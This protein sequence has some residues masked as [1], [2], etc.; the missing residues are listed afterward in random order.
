MH[1]WVTITE[2]PTVQR[3][4]SIGKRKRREPSPVPKIVMFY[5]YR[6][7]PCR[8]LKVTI[9]S[10]AQAQ[11]TARNTTSHC[12]SLLFCSDGSNA[13]LLLQ[14][15]CVFLDKISVTTSHSTKS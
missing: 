9:K 12:S 11:A 14:T 10:T 1:E 5:V 6:R 7:L 8:R 2:T 3:H 13:Q 4:S 15:I